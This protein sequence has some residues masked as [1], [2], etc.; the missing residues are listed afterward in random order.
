MGWRGAFNADFHDLEL[1]QA[2]VWLTLPKD[3][4]ESDTYTFWQRSK[5]P[6]R[7]AHPTRVSLECLKT[8]PENTAILAKETSL[9]PG[10]VP[11][12][13]SYPIHTFLPYPL[14]YYLSD[15]HR[16]AQDYVPTEITAPD[17]QTSW[18]SL[19]ESHWWQLSW[20]HWVEESRQLLLFNLA[21]ICPSSFLLGTTLGYGRSPRSRAS[22]DARRT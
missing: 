19:V 4:T 12:A 15:T 2:G 8:F 11:R 6:R 17:R 18:Q 13:S 16:R 10:Q 3:S 1:D 22:R 14:L 7:A 5:W 9:L 21:S 20:S